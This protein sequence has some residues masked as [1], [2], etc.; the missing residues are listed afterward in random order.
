VLTR[1]GY[2]EA[3]RGTNGFTCLVLRSFHGDLDDATFWNP[4]FQAPHCLNAPAV[5][6]ILP[7]M[8]KRAEWILSGVPRS[9]I[10]ARTKQA[11][12]THEFPLPA[13]GAMAYMLSHE[14]YLAEANPHW[15]P[16]LMFYFDR[17]MPASMWGAGGM[18]APV[19]DGSA[20]DK[21]F[22]VETLLIPVPQWS[23]GSPFSPG[24]GH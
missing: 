20:S 14:Q 7:E 9:D 15:K 16:H 11:Y 24:A 1:T 21:Q 6:S 2:V 19:I 4:R 8:E 18:S 13:A 17:S 5:R 23:D 22:P 10:A 3:A 12:A